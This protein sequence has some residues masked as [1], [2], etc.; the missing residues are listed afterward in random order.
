MVCAI[1]LECLCSALAFYGYSEFHF[2]NGEKKREILFLVYLNHYVLSTM[3]I[4]T[5][6][7]I[8]F[9]TLKNC[10][11]VAVVAFKPEL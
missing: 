9:A 3:D 11:I 1:I 6:I 8:F 7:Y 10:M 5:Q 4:L 2:S